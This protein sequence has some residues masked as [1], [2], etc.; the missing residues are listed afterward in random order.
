MVGD[1]VV[2]TITVSNNGPSTAT[3]IEISDAL[4]S[5]YTYVSDNGSGTYVP[6]TGLWTIASIGASAN[7][8]LNITASVNATLEFPQLKH[9]SGCSFLLSYS[10]P[11]SFPVL[12]SFNNIKF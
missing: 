1:N 10:R 12:E 2:F 4:P 6:G 5:G 11:V 8:V 3:G 7:E 9:L